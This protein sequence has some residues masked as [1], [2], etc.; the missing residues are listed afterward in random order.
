MDL[1]NLKD[2]MNKS[3]K[4]IYALIST[5]LGSFLTP[6]MSSSFNVSLPFM[7]KEFNKALK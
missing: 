7:G 4:K 2:I 6:F 5:M 3:S 1:L